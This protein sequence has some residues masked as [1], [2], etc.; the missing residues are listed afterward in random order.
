M[1]TFITRR[2]ISSLLMI[3][4]VSTVVFGLTHLS[5]DP[6]RVILGAETT[7]E[8]IEAMRH[9]LGFDRP[10]YVQYFDFMGR[11]VRGDLGQ[12]LYYR[13]D[14]LGLVAER[15][16]AT[17]ELTGVAML[18]ALLISIPAGILA[19]VYQNSWIDFFSRLIAIIGQSFPAYWV[20]IM[21]IIFF[22][23]RFQWL[24]PG[25]RGTPA[26]LLLPAIT[27]GLWPMA[28]ISRVLRA[29]MIETLRQDYIRT[30]TGKGLSRQAV[31]I[32]HAFRNALIPTVNIIGLTIGLLLGGAVI[33][34]FVFSWPGLGRLALEA[35]TNRD[36]PLV[37]AI[38]LVASIAFVA[39]NFAIDIVIGWLDPRIRIG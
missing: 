27:L 13:E 29:S 6:V 23:V 28:Q 1:I 33:T 3:F 14:T 39:I 30:A 10:L 18:F 9:E 11:A 38:V 17:L 2:A 16:P 22:A 26:H 35:I 15:L 34:E 5:G 19:A 25:G 36:F 20:G 31:I 32:R 37:Q 4:L 7:L 21:L 8:Q 24:P 12:S